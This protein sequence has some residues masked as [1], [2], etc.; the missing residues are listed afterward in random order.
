MDLIKLSDNLDDMKEYEPLPGG[1]YPAEIREIEVKH[2]EKQPDGYFVISLMI[3]P[4]D[5]PADYEVENAPNGVVVT[6]AR[7]AVPVA[8]NR[9]TI[10]PF[11]N[12]IKAMGLDAGGD[13]FNPEEWIGKG[14]QVFLSRT[15]YQGAP[16][17]NV[18][19]VGPIPT[20]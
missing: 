6:Y 16:V 19:G 4:N 3:D 20:V 17:N 8:T 10:R 11:K 9:K 14:L 18:E 2:S 12:L 7:V 1:P 15:E 13:T 5:F